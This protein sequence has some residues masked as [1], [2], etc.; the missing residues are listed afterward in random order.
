MSRRILRNPTCKELREQM[1][2]LTTNELE[3]KEAKQAF[4]HLAECPACREALA[5]HVKLTAALFG[6]MGGQAHRSA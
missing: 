5:E 1:F 2:L 6:T 3:D 4:L